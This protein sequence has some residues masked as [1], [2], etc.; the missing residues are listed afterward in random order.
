MGLFVSAVHPSWAET[1][2]VICVEAIAEDPVD[3]IGALRAAERARWRIIRKAGREGR[4]L[5]AGSIGMGPGDRSRAVARELD[6]VG[7]RH[8]RAMGEAR[9][10]CECRARR[11]DPDGARCDR[12]YPRMGP[13][14]SVFR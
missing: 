3:E 9:Q 1:D 14:E 12:L 5:L 7:A 6:E 8:R 4:K 11:H 10:L 13:G 2:S